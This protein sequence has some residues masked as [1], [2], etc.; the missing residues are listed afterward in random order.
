MGGPLDAGDIEEVG[1]SL[2][3]TC[4][5]HRYKITLAGGEGLYQTAPGVWKSK[6]VRQRVHRLRIGDANAVAESD[7]EAARIALADAWLYVSLDSTVASVASDDYNEPTR[8]R[9]LQARLSKQNEPE[10]RFNPNTIERVRGG[11]NGAAAPSGAVPQGYIRS[12]AVFASNRAAGAPSSGV[13]IH[14]TRPKQ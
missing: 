11:P 7:A 13:A 10:P 9:A 12:G 4:P 5:W 2:A 1:G 8:Y 3:V 6:G 14:S